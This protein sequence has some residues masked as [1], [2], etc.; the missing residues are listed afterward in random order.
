MSIT[1]HNKVLITK[2]TFRTINFKFAIFNAEYHVASQENKNSVFIV[3][4]SSSIVED[5]FN[6][7][8][9]SICI[10]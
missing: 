9:V 6:M 1:I 8:R 3:E 2:L 7:F 5:E 10:D 4:N